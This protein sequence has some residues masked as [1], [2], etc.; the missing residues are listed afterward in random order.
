MTIEVRDTDHDQSWWVT[1]DAERCTTA[2]LGD[3]ADARLVGPAGDLYQVLW[4][5]LACDV[6]SVEGDRALIDLWRD[7][8]HVRWS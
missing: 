3:H 1:F 6:V 7:T 2:R 8:V 4:N 5:R